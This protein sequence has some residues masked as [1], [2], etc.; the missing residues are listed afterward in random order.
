MFQDPRVRRRFNYAFDFEEMNRTIFF[1]QYERIDSFFY[2]IPLRWEGL[3]EGRSW[4][5]SSRSATR[6]R[7]RCSPPSTPTRSAAIRRRSA[8]T[9]AGR[10]S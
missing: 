7:R 5:S 2:G 1:G 9:C 8:T 4:K 6:C 10:A 3:P